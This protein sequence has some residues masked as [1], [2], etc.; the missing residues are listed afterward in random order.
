MKTVQ[1]Y[2]SERTG[3]NYRNAKD[4]LKDEFRAMQKEL[5]II[6]GL[7]PVF[8]PFRNLP[9]QF[10]RCRR[11]LDALESKQQ[12]IVTFTLPTLESQHAKP[13]ESDNVIPLRKAA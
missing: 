3:K 2:Q 13:A 9:D 10:A 11:L 4:A 6:V 8:D 12:E 7:I 5:A 1:A